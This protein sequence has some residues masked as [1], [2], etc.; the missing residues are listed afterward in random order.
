M[1]NPRTYL[2]RIKGA[3]PEKFI[4]VTLHP[5][6]SGIESKSGSVSERELR[7]FLS[8][9]GDPDLRIEE[10]DTCLDRARRHEV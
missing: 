5:D 4:F 6:F 7:E 1:E 9:Y 2:A 8:T 3:V 10:I